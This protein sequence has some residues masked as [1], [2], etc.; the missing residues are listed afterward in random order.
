MKFIEMQYGPFDDEE[1]KLYT[2]ILLK[3]ANG[4]CIIQ[5][6]QKR[7]IFD[8]FYKYFKDVES[9]KAIN[10][11]QYI[12]LVLSAKRILENSNMVLL[13]NILTG[14]ITKYVSRKTVNK[15]ILQYIE[16]SPSYNMV[17]EKYRSD[18]IKKHIVSIIGTILAS[19]FNII[20]KDPKICGYTIDT[21]SV[22]PELVEQVLIYI[23]LC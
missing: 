22:I 4:N 13:A 9:I 17:I 20:D 10:R 21:I 23:L 3:D 16:S 15:R 19:E 12:K 1:I 2:D 5:E 11:D 6:F 8:M 14:N 7:S 18:T